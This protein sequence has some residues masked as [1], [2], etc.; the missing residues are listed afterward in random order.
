MSGCTPAA[1]RAA[2]TLYGSP[3]TSDRF[4]CIDVAFLAVYDGVI[5]RL[6]TVIVQP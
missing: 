4:G 6:G 2:L 5:V 3:I 1:L